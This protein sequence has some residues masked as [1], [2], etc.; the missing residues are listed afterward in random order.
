MRFPGFEDAWEVKKLGEVAT[1]FMYG[2]NTAATVYD[3][4]NQYIRITDIDERTRL[5]TP[6]PLSSPDGELEDKYLLEK[7]DILFARTGA[8]VGKSYLYSEKD[9]KIFFAGFLIRL[10]VKTENPYFIFSQTL[11][12]KYQKWVLT[13]SMRSGQ[14]GINAEEYKLLPIALP[15]FEEQ[16]EIAFFLSKID[17]RIQAQSKIIEGLKK[18]KVATAKKIFSQEFRFKDNNGN[19]FSKWEEMKLKNIVIIQMGQ[20]PDSSSYNFENIGIPLIQGNADILNRKS[21]PRQY[22]SKPTKF[23][24][25]GDLLLTV[26]APV[27]YVGKSK[28]YACIG[29]GICSV[30]NNDKSILEFIYQFL[31]YFEDKWKS[32]EQGS[33]FTAVNSSDINSINI[34]LPSIP[35]QAKIANFLSAID[36]KI[37][38]ENQLLQKLEEQKKF[39]LQNMF[40]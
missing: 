16:S 36:S 31:L 19:D 40:V 39:L 10:N 30:K 28:H 9:G 15:S 22:T 7:G 3:G 25:V 12:E 8:S 35:E 23:C 1:N 6:N 29:R 4:E 26:R 13:M 34:L 27:G 38:M 32:I 18:L 5:F 2:M 14:P 21:N 24:D 37:D 11:T 17:E 20:S 33:T